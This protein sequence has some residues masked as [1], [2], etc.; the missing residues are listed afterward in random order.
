MADQNVGESS[1][2]QRRAEENAT[3]TLNGSRTL[4]HWK[5]QQRLVASYIDVCYIQIGEINRSS[6]MRVD[7]SKAN[8]EV[9]MT[10]LISRRGF[11]L[12]YILKSCQLWFCI[13]K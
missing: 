12:K 3:L 5:H 8:T 9:S 10:M 7:V 6:Q 13:I 2:P 1:I 4:W 11:P